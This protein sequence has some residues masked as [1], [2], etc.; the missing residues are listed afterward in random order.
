M[1]LSQEQEEGYGVVHHVEW[2]HHQ[3]HLLRHYQNTNIQETQIRQNQL[4]VSRDDKNM[5]EQSNTIPYFLKEYCM[6]TWA[7][8]YRTLV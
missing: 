8:A 3:W 4:Q 2:E 1:I 5:G 6:M 7:W